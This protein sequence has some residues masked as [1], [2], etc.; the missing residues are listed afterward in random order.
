MTGSVIIFF[1]DGKR[2]PICAEAD[3]II[4]DIVKTIGNEVSVFE[5]YPRKKHSLMDLE[6]GIRKCINAAKK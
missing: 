3:V 2:V 1:S 6:S 4:N 5:G